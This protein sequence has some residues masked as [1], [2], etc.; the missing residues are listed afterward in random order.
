MVYLYVKKL[1]D[2]KYFGRTYRD[3]H[4]YIGS[5]T[6][7]LNHVKKYGRKNI[8]TVDVW[9]FDSIEEASV[10]AILFSKENNI[11]ESDHWANLTEE[12]AHAGAGKGNIPW[13]RGIPNSKEH[14]IKAGKAISEYW[15]THEHP[16]KGTPSWNSGKTNC[17]SE[18]TKK[19]WSKSRIGNKSKSNWHDP[20]IYKFFHSIYGEYI[21]TRYDMIRNYP[22]QKLNLHC[23][24]RVSLGTQK[25]HLG[26][27][28]LDTISD[29]LLK[30]TK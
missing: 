24:R 15:K 28:K 21:G 26:W 1:N 8:E 4:K 27:V 5:G 20:T 2:L 19:K 3:P 30:D 29:S 6:R 11:V 12:D 18:E 9:K 10:F 7:W 14:N 23:L 13:N 25:Q 16:R 17:Y 22:N